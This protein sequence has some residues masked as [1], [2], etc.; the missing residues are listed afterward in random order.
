[1]RDWRITLVIAMLAR[2]DRHNPHPHSDGMLQL[3][4]VGCK[5]EGVSD[6]SA[7]M[8]WQ[9]N[10]D[11]SDKKFWA[12]MS[13]LAH[14]SSNPGHWSGF[15]DSKISSHLCQP[16]FARIPR[17]QDGDSWTSDT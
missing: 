16:T 1:M 10:D 6:D 2:V 5:L 15:Q 8:S 17:F 13:L 9:L 7:D 12:K 4:S 11:I 3:G 14:V